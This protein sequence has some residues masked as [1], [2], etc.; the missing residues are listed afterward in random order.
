MT[1]QEIFDKITQH[2]LTQRKVS[3][4]IE[5]ICQYRNPEGLKCAV[6]CLIEDQYYD[7]SLEGK[8]VN[9]EVVYSAVLKSTRAQRSTEFLLMLKKTQ[10]IHDCENRDEWYSCLENLAKQFSLGF[11]PPNL[12]GKDMA[13]L[14]NPV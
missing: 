2:L 11:N 6:G 1:I 10:V 3:L 4:D 14:T 8:E 12:L 5:G 7:K 13:G 9:I